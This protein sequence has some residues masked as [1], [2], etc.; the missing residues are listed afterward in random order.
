MT[1]YDRILYCVS[2][3][4]CGTLIAFNAA[5]QSTPS[6]T[7]KAS[8]K[9]PGFRAG[10]VVKITIIQTNI[11]D[12]QVNCDYFGANAVNNAYHYDVRDEDG[13]PVAKVQWTKPVPPLSRYLQCSVEP[14]KSN[15]NWIYLSN[16]YKL[17]K[18]GKY[19]IQVSRP[20][21]DTKDSDGKPVEV[22]SNTITITITG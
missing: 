19:T 3:F 21:P 9:N 1:R 12:H 8:P 6:F 18:P 7:L 22:Q 15:T 4:L 20:D 14:G 16:A 10:D 13:N 17:D 2:I 11:S 5:A